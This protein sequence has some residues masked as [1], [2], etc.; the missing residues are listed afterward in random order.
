MPKS[1]Q[2][3]QLQPEGVIKDT[4]E[5]I[6]LNS[7]EINADLVELYEKEA[8]VT[9]RINAHVNGSAEKH[10]AE[11]IVFTPSESITATETQSAI[12]QVNER[13]SNIISQSGTSDTEV[14]DA[15]N[16]AQ[17]GV[18]PTLKDRLDEMD[19][20]FEASVKSE[21]NKD[22]C[23]LAGVIRN[24]NG[25]WQFIVDSTHDKTNL[26]TVSPNG[27]YDIE[28]GYGFTAKKVNSIVITPDE[29]FQQFGISV[30]ASVGIVSTL[31]RASMAFNCEILGNG[32][33]SKI[34]EP[35][36]NSTVVSKS[37]ETLTVTH[38]PTIQND[39]PI[40]SSLNSVGNPEARIKSYTTN[41]VEIE[42][43]SD[44]NGYVTFD[45]ST[46]NCNTSNINVPTFSFSNGVLTVNHEQYN[47]PYSI[48]ISGRDGAYIPALGSVGAYSF[49]VIFKDYAGNA[50]NVA[51]TNMKFFFHVASKVKSQIPNDMKVSV[52]RGNVNIPTADL[53][54]PGAN[55]WIFGLMEI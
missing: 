28:L 38:S 12:E 22:V 16:S 36:A 23:V 5:Q 30:G 41:S 19:S 14:V 50:I 35:L 43:F 9:E 10:A 55:F 52:R 21:Q 25:E 32:Q 47:N 34:P 46:F 20:N 26:E 7:A 18:Y 51:D 3:R 39:I 37:N 49:Q 24:I 1:Y 53:D 17:G 8:A 40:I 4:Y 33:I 48:T 6:N 54:I 29:T 2:N 44:A 27:I 42:A 11:S 15:R 45:G 13:V 31:I